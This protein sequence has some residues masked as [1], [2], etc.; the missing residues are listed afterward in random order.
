M[1]P[2]Q[3][4]AMPTDGSRQI[5]A[6]YIVGCD[7]GASAV[8]RQ[9]G[10][11]LRGEGEPARACT[12]RSTTARRC[13]TAFRS[14]MARAGDVTTISPTARPT[15]LIMQ[16][17][18]RHWTLH[19]TVERPE[20][21]AAQFERTVG[22]PVP[23]EMLYVGAVEAEPA[24]GGP[25][26]RRSRVSRRRF[27]APGDSDRRPRHEHRRRRRDRSVVEAPGD[28]AGVGRAEPAALVR[29]RTTPGRRPQ[30]RCLALCVAR[31]AQMARAVPARHPGGDAGGAGDA[32]RPLRG[33]PTSSSAR[34]TR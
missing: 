24:A 14:A 20:D 26:P 25:L 2:S 16:D 5:R 10:I 32:R 19:A 18:T 31:A 21:M 3:R 15:F 4:S 23:Y 8:R 12:R 9:L 7:G 11:Q 34:R 27:G 33:R 17:S 30:R 22:M 1:A 13:S 29:D 6:R 28:A